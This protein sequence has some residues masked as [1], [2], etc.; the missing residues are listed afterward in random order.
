M[1]HDIKVPPMGESINEA[2][3]AQLMK[4]SGNTVGMDEEIVE[5]EPTK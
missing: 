4:A 1:K 3:V 5:L 2:T